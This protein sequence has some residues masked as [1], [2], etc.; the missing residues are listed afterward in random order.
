MLRRAG[1]PCAAGRPGDGFDRLTPIIL[2][3][4][5]GSDSHLRF[6]HFSKA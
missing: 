5:S 1:F 2:L 3:R 6:T 4:L